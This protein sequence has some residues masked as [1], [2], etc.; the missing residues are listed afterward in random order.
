MLNKFIIFLLFH[1]SLN[2]MIFP[3]NRVTLNKNGFITKDSPEY[4][5]TH[6][7]IDNFNTKLYTQMKIGNPFQKV[8]VLLSSETCAFKIGKSKHCI[9]DDE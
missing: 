1:V 4:N 7:A 5:G 3:F 6:F 9:Y 8:K 2:M